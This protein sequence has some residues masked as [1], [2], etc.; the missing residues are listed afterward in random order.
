MN[1]LMLGCSALALSGVLGTLTQASADLGMLAAVGEPSMLLAQNLPGNTANPYN[2]P[3]RRINPNS[4]QGT[5]PST[6]VIRGPSTLPVP[7]TPTV[8]N[9][10]IGNGYPRPGTPAGTIQSDTLPTPPSRDSGT[11]TR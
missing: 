1:R 10:G 5:Q 6:P 4:M 3:I 9:G 7:R 8:E 2:S 11:N